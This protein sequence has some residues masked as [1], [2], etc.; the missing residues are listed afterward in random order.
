[1]NILVTG[2]AGYIGSTFSFSC[3]KKGFNI[4]GV[5]NFINSSK[6]NIQTLENQFAENF[7]F[8][9]LDLAGNFDNVEEK[10]KNIK[11]DIAVHFAGLKAV[12]ES[13]KFPI[14]YWENNLISTFNLVKLLEKKSVKK[15]IFSSS[16][17]VYGHNENQ[18]VKEIDITYPMSCYGSTKIA[19]EFFLKDITA[20]TGIDVISLRYFNPVGAHKEKMICEEINQDPNNIMPRIL[21]VAKGIDSKLFV[22]G[23]DFETK[24][25]SGERDYIHVEDLVEAHICA[26]NKTGKF[27]TYDVFNIGTGSK[28]SVL[29]LVKTFESINNIKIPY[30]ISKRR[31]G[32]VPVC[33]A[34]PT[35]A[36]NLLGWKAK[37][38]L[39]EMCRDAWE[40][41]IAN[42]P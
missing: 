5:D 34:D 23:D 26:I 21:R 30:E 29:E 37:K 32:D 13:Q 28:Y 16:A 14:K 38:D 27:D 6:K 40:A 2:A 18:P 42:E 11:P 31:E 8:I 22:F 15:L 4:V 41:V 36:E 25:G 10:L 7:S 39:P 24:D 12:G 1:M 9:E 35:K 20:S 3:L 33:Y 19:N 17:T